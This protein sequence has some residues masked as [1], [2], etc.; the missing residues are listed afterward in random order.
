MRLEISV[1][2]VGNLSDM[3]G[4]IR[5]TC[6]ANDLQCTQNSLHMPRSAPY[7]HHTSTVQALYIHRTYTK[8]TPYKHRTV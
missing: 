5:N 4:G 6:T 8:Q 3:M 2:L 1:I 7:V